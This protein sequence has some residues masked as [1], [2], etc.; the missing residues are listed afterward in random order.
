MF[1]S[2]LAIYFL[3]CKSVCAI[4]K[5]T[6]AYCQNIRP[7]AI[8]LVEN[9]LLHWLP[10][11][12]RIKFKTLLYM[13]RAL[14]CLSLVYLSDCITIYV[15][16]HQEKVYVPTKT[17]TDLL[18][19]GVKN[20]SAMDPSVSPVQLTGTSYHNINIFVYHPLFML[21]NVASKPIF[22]SN[23]TELTFLIV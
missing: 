14:N 6:Y 12:K 11:D 17:Q 16:Y 7:G 9:F 10:I 1:I 19:L 2:N 8:W 22:S 4:Q 21:S 5:S 18:F 15:M 13:F 3:C 20:G 23:F